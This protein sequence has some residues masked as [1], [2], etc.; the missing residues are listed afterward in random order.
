MQFFLLKNNRSTWFCEKF[1]QTLKHNFWISHCESI[2]RFYMLCSY[3]GDARAVKNDAISQC[4]AMNHIWI[5]SVQR[6][7]Q[8]RIINNRRRGKKN[9]YR[10]I[11]KCLRLFKV[12]LFFFYHQSVWDSHQLMLYSN[13]VMLIKTYHSRSSMMFLFPIIINKL[14]AINFALGC[15]V[16]A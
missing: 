11:L 9:Y 1:D 14:N 16:I 2:M 15:I 6:W 7:K 12:N 13:Q 8:S 10:P 3:D 4:D 5:E